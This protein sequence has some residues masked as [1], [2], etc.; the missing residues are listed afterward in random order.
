MGNKYKLQSPMNIW[1][2]ELIKTAFYILCWFVNPFRAHTQ[3]AL[4]SQDEPDVSQKS[5][6]T[7]YAI[8]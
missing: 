4:L 3:T 2:V 6:I 5:I 1:V 8:F 7:C